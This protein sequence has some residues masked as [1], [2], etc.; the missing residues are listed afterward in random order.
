LDITIFE[1]YKRGNNMNETYSYFSRPRH[2][3]CTEQAP[4]TKY[5]APMLVIKNNELVVAQAV[6]D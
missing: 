4:T 1:I 6:R 5:S 2:N 3:V